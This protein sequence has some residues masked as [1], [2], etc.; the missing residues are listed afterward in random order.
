MVICNFTDHEV[1]V[2]EAVMDQIPDQS[3]VLIANYA[4]D[5]GKVLR[6]YEAK[7]YRY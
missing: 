6:P 3:E 5:E 4:D 2:S 7:V 1:T